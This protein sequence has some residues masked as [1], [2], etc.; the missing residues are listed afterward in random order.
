MKRPPLLL[1][2]LLL[3]LLP[4]LSGCLSCESQICDCF[5]GPEDD[6]WLAFDADST[7][8]GFRRAELA[9]AYVVRYARPG[10]STAL[11]TVRI[12][13]T[14]SGPFG[15]YGLGVVLNYLFYPR[16]SAQDVPASNYAVVLPRVNRRYQVADIE[17][18]GETRGSR[19]C[20][21]YA[22]TRK[23]FSLDGT[24][25]IADGQERKPVAVLRR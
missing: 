20:K 22:N 19:C 1:A 24:F 8:L 4:G 3:L 25:V 17:L 13:P 6:I 15:G 23:R 10:F 14:P 7:N 2:L 9:G 18:A 21:C 16:Q 12:G 5:D 11:D